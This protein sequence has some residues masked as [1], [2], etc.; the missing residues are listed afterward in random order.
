MLL[1][2][3]TDTWMRMRYTGLPV[4]VPA[5]CTIDASRTVTDRMEAAS[6][7]KAG[8]CLAARLEAAAGLVRSC[9]ACRLTRVRLALQRSTGGVEQGWLQSKV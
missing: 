5:P 4:S 3:I 1:T 9:S 8:S 2:R 6:T 7:P